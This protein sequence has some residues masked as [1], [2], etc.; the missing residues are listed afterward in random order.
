MWESHTLLSINLHAQFGHTALIIA[1]INDNQNITE[2]LIIKKAN[3]DL[4]DDVRI[5][6]SNHTCVHDI[7]NYTTT[8][9]MTDLSQ[10]L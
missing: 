6:I 4:Q 8:T 5:Q 9:H 3:T 10:I 1:A 7:N 2:L